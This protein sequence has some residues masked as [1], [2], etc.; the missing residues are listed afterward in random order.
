MGDSPHRDRLAERE[1]AQRVGREHLE[2][3]WERFRRQGF[4]GLGDP[5]HN[6]S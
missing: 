6:K 2:R 1:R 5:P 3:E 4:Y